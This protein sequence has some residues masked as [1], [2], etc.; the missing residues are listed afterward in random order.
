MMKSIARLENSKSWKWRKVGF[1][2]NWTDLALL[3]VE[4]STFKKHVVPPRL[5]EEK[6]SETLQKPFQKTYY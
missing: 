5:S 1:L 3:I 2:Y 6:H 4:V